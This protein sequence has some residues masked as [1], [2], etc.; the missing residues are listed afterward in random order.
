MAA[1]PAHHSVWPTSTTIPLSLTNPSVE[2]SY[3]QSPLPALSGPDDILKAVQADDGGKAWKEC[4]QMPSLVQA[5]LIEIGEARDPRIGDGEKDV[6]WIGEE[7]WIYKCQFSLPYPQSIYEDE[8][9]ELEKEI[10]FEGLDTIAV[11]YLDGKEILRSENMFHTHRIPL[12]SSSLSTTSKN[13]TL[14]LIFPSAFLHARKIEHF[15]TKNVVWNGD[16]SRVWVRK[17][18]FGWGWDWGPVV[19]TVGPWKPIYISLFPRWAPRVVDWFPNPTIDLESGKSELEI[20]VTV[21]VPT[22]VAHRD[23]M[24]GTVE[25]CERFVAQLT[26]SSLYHASD[27]NSAHLNQTTGSRVLRK[28]AL[29][30]DVT[31]TNLRGD[32]SLRLKHKWEIE[33]REVDWW[34]PNGFGGAGEGDGQWKPS[35][36]EIRLEVVDT[37]TGKPLQTFT[38]SIGFRSVRLV[39][40]PLDDEE[41]CTFFFE[42]NGKSM[43]VGGA[44]W[45][46]MDSFLTTTTPIRYR[47]W[48]EKLVEARMT[49]VRVWGGGIYE[50]DEFYSI[51]DEL[52]ILVWQDFA[53]ACG[54]YPAHPSFLSSVRK[55]AEDN[56]RRLRSHPSLVVLCGNNEDYQIAESE[57]LEYDPQDH[58]GDWTKTTFPAREIYERLLPSVVSELAPDIY[59]HPGSPWGGKTSRDPTVGDIHQWNVWHGTQEPY[60]NWDQLSGRFVSEFG[61]QG[62][63]SEKTVDFW[64]DGNQGERFPQSRMIGYHNKAAGFERRLELYL[65]ENIRHSFD[66]P[67]YIYAT[68]LIQAETL[69]WAYRVWRR[70]WKGPGKEYNAGALVWQLNDVYPCTSWSIVD[71]FL[72]PKPAYFAI[73]SALAPLAINLKRVTRQVRRSDKPFTALVKE[74]VFV[75]AWITSSL[76]S[77]CSCVYTLEA[78]DLVTGEKVEGWGTAETGI[79]VEVEAN[80]SKELGEWKISGYSGAAVVKGGANAY[81]KGQLVVCGTLRRAG[82]DE[83]LGRHSSWPEPYKFLSF[84]SPSTTA[85]SICPHQSTPAALTFQIS[86]QTPVKGLILEL[87]S[88]DYE[89]EDNCLDL[90]PREQRLLKVKRRLSS[91]VTGQNDV[92]LKWKYLSKENGETLDLGANVNGK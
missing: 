11:V 68:Q 12:P 42:I 32:G 43:W 5:E 28:S 33:K 83:I 16:S 14:H 17:A 2:W 18:G 49:M 50:S 90:I 67:S 29:E 78:F 91:E 34:Y 60:Q 19:M 31:Q 77:P 73:R 63:P 36:Y 88:D 65:V 1:K 51:C 47:L 25:K 70:N 46:P 84:P 75:E 20:E 48:L 59:Y 24:T 89:L 35:L 39:Q 80:R 53:F 57:G 15:S 74:E 87:S 76:L 4:R 27:S 58:D 9:D 26:L 55:E 62:F 52:G 82:S 8:H 40:R 72:R 54:Q 71:Y 64:L 85:L 6:Q 86:A 13:H 56:V 23:H 92:V 66:I 7:D 22:A 37:L 21:T 44:N 30:I 3:R 38:K 10:I 61:M 81:N 45:I 69:S 41:G 79:A